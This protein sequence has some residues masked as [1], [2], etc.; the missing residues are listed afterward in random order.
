MSHDVKQIKVFISHPADVKKETEIIRQAIGTWNDVHS[1]DQ[2]LILKPVEWES[3]TFPEQGNSAQETINRQLLYDCDLLIAVFWTRLGTPTENASSG[4]AEEIQKHLLQ[5]KPAML[6]F[7]DAP[8]SP[9]L[10]DLSQYKALK[11]F[12]LKLSGLVTLYKSLDQFKDV[13]PQHLEKQIIK[14]RECIQERNLSPDPSGFEVH[15]LSSDEEFVKVRELDCEAYGESNVSE[16]TLKRWWKGYPQGIYVARKRDEIIGALGIFPLSAETYRALRNG[17][18]S[19]NELVVSKRFVRSSR[20]QHWYVSGVVIR[21]RHR[22]TRAL[23]RLLHG[24]LQHWYKTQERKERLIIGSIPVSHEGNVLLTRYL[25]SEISSPVARK[26]HFPFYERV[27]DRKDIGSII[28]GLNE[29][30]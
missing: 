21:E 10:I 3:C 7:S 19:E 24:A 30:C 12:K 2:K 27:F 17:H 9:S 6:Y 15:P 29:L 25:F 23:F 16:D 8:I 22:K 11:K 20:E 13:F 5:G 14:M 1:D 18:I 26:D 4:T 28:S